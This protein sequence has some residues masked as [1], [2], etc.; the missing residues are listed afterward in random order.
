MLAAKHV[1]A[2]ARYARYALTSLAAVAF[3]ILTS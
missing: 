1:A 2:H 3:R